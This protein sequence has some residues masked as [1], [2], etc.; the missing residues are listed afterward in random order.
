MKERFFKIL[1]RESEKKE[2]E[3]PKKTIGLIIDGPNILR[4]EFG[5]K[6]EDILEALKRIG[7]VRVA[8]VIL[9]QYAPQ[10]LIEAVVNQGL[11]PVIVAG[12]TDVRVAIEAM[13]LIY[14]SDVDVIALA[15][16][17]ADFLPIIIEAKR[18]GKETV[19]IGVDPGFSVALQ[20]AADYVIK[21][22]GRKTPENKE[23]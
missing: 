16:R 8:K 7:N 2:E 23:G 14:N 21:M 5:I 12:D 4:K 18:R 10:G 22:E 6:L 9:N 11:E 15:S 19:V 17:D 3:T 13:E 1:K 20:N